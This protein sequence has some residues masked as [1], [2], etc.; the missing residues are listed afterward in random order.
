MPAV[1]LKD[2]ARKTGK[3]MSTVSRALS[4]DPRVKPAT[5]EMIREAVA[6]LGYVPNLQARALARGKTGV[7][8]FICGGLTRPHEQAPA[9]HASAILAER[10]IDCYLVQ[11]Q[12]KK[13]IFERILRNLCAGSADGALVIPGPPIP[14]EIDAMLKEKQI[15]II[16][17]DRKPTRTR[18]PLVSTDNKTS[19]GLLAEHTATL[20]MT[21]CVMDFPWSNNASEARHK[22]FLERASTLGMDVEIVQMEEEHLKT[23]RRERFE[24]TCFVGSTQG[25]IL[26]ITRGAKL[27]NCVSLCYDFWV[28][29]PHPFK[30]A[31]IVEQDF[32]GMSE[33]ACNLMIDITSGNAPA[34]K[35]D[36]LL[37]HLGIQEIQS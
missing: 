3:D 23:L 1:T 13:E 19:A 9:M 27:K 10:G 6:Q 12:G 32:R 31:Y 34:R 21:R 8:W 11:H 33:H 35:K 7:F 18:F 24:N 25:R 22:G 30:K 37:P 15:P 5:A 20:G 2:I 29:G 17:I 28:G 36:I 14:R 16:W 26:N 4:N